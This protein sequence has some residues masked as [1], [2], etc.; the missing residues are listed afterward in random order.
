[1]NALEIT[2]AVLGV[3]S[4]AATAWVTGIVAWRVLRGPRP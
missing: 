2:F 4:F 1:M 3:S